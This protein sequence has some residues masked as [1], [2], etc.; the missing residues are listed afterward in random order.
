MKKYTQFKEFL[1]F[2]SFF[3]ASG[4]F[5]RE[6]KVSDDPYTVVINF[7]VFF[8]CLILALSYA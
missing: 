8:N 6:M 2:L 3:G 5:L 1:L 7:L 4:Y